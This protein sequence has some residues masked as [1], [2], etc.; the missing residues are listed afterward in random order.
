MISRHRNLMWL[1]TLA[2][3]STSAHAER[4]FVHSREP[5]PTGYLS[6]GAE[7]F[8]ATDGADESQSAFL[9]GRIV[10]QSDTEIAIRGQALRSD[11]ANGNS[12]TDAGDTMLSIVQGF[13]TPELKWAQYM[14]IE[15][16]TVIHSAPNGLQ[17]TLDHYFRARAV[18]GWTRLGYD[19]SLTAFDDSNVSPGQAKRRDTTSLGARSQFGRFHLG[20]DV[21]FTHMSAGDDPATYDF[22]VLYRMMS[23]HAI[24]AFA[25]KGFSGGDESE[26]VSLS[27]EFRF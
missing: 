3:G 13:R 15:G 22:I 8:R 17:S 19:V 21:N 2:L 18:G 6:A 25:E 10:F 16:G 4:F 12:R 5:A 11:D 9:E 24:Y 23:G 1:A 7:W 26:Y 14:S 20:A 27:I